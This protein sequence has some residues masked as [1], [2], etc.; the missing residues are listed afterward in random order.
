MYTGKR[1]KMIEHVLDTTFRFFLHSPGAYWRAKLASVAL[2]LKTERS[3]T[4]M[5]RIAPKMPYCPQSHTV[6]AVQQSSILIR[7][8]GPSADQ[9]RCS[10][11]AVPTVCVVYW[12]ERWK[13]E[14]RKIWA[15]ASTIDYTY[16]VYRDGVRSHDQKPQLVKN[17]LSNPSVPYLKS[18]HSGDCFQQLWWFFSNKLTR[19]IAFGLLL[20]CS[21][22]DPKW[23]NKVCPV[24]QFTCSQSLVRA[25]SQRL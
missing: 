7:C 10:D 15:T 1:S 23:I 11:L 3:Q 4:A 9:P 20:V 21:G 12:W 24:F 8:F 6:S 2:H 13:C 18:Q 22:S 14:E 25:A 19:G 5:S 17:R 16:C